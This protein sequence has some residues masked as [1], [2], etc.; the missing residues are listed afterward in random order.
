MTLIEARNVKKSYLMGE[1]KVHALAGVSLK[2]NEGDFVVILGPS[3][4]GKSTLMH[5]LG[6]LDKPTSGDV[7][8]R[9]QKLAL[10]EDDELAELRRNTIGFI[11]QSFHLIPTLSALENVLIP[12]EPL[13]IP[14]EE[15]IEKAE[16]L[17]DTVGLSDRLDHKPGELSG[18]QRQRVSIARA[19]I[20]NPSIVFADEPTGNLDTLTGKHVIDLMRHLNKKEKKTFVVVTHDPT[21]VRFATKTFYLRDGL[22]KHR[23]K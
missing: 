16:R 11:F 9:N 12:T 6:A 5:T 10:L 14:Y 13:N 2:I 18:G 8:I 20:N 1:T 4:S 23:R 7:L 3:G 17:L 21:L 15:R 19:L 22:L